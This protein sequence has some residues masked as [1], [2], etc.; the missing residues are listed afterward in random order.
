MKT[1]AFDGVETF[2]AVAELKSFTAAAARLGITPAAASKAVKVL[3]LRHG[4]ILFQRTTRNVALTEAGLSLFADLR[5]AAAQVGDAFAAL[6]AYRDS[7]IGTLRLTVPRALGAALVKNLVAACRR[8][9]P[10]VKIDIS[11]DDGAVDLIAQGFDAGIRLGHAVAQD[12]V[13]IQLTPALRW[14]AMKRYVTVLSVPAPWRAGNSRGMD[15]NSMSR[16]RAA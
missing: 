12:M 14:S 15:R 2:L 7:P 3:E 4:V 5:P 10:D 9:Y 6:T 16:R 11:L 13:A 8:T 1:N